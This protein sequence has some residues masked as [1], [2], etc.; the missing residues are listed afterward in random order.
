MAHK[1]SKIVLLYFFTFEQLINLFSKQRSIIKIIKQVWKIVRHLSIV[2][3]AKVILID[4]LSRTY[5]INRVVIIKNE[6][7]RKAVTNRPRYNLLIFSFHHLDGNIPQNEQQIGTFRDLDV[8]LSLNHEQY[9]SREQYS[10]IILKK[11]STNRFE[12][13]IEKNQMQSICTVVKLN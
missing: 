2:S 5:R 4:V 12:S 11:S 1:V 13:Q 6:A 3:P 8:K 9:F 10:L 7:Y